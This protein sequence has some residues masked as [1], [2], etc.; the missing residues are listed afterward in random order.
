MPAGSSSPAPR[1]LVRWIEH[2]RNAMSLLPLIASTSAKSWYAS[3]GLE[4]VDAIENNHRL[5]PVRR[6]DRRPHSVTLQTT[7]SIR[8]GACVHWRAPLIGSG[9]CRVRSLCSY[10]AAFFLF[11]RRQLQ[12]IRTSPLMRRRSLMRPSARGRARPR[13]RA[14]G[15]SGCGRD[16]CD[17]RRSRRCR[18]WPRAFRFHGGGPKRLVRRQLA[19]QQALGRGDP[20]GR[21]SQARH[22]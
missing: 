18:W 13:A 15:R 12:R 11:P 22:A 4:E 6:R 10:L 5:A 1:T 19:H 16:A 7:Y 2:R 8:W 3:S 17:R 14:P 20:H 9:D 21:R